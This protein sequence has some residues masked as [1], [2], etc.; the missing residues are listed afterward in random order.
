MAGQDTEADRSIPDDLVDPITHLLRN[1]ADH[2]IEQLEEPLGS[3][4]MS[5]REVGVADYIVEPFQPNMVGEGVFNAL[6]A[7]GMA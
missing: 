3:K 6:A 5:K 2:G 4:I 1:A 7:G